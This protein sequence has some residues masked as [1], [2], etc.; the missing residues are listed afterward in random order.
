MDK[1]FAED[2][3]N[4]RIVEQIRKQPGNKHY[5]YFFPMEDAESVLLID[6]WTDQETLDKHHKSDMMKQ[7]NELK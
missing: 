7:I 6:Q 5:E 2:I 4:K 3:V 1:Q